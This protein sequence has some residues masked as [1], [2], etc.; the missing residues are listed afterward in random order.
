MAKQIFTLGYQ[1]LTLDVFIAC[2]KSEGLTTVIDVRANPLSRKRG[3]SKKALA[4]E[5]SAV[6]IE[7]KHLPVFGCPKSVRDRYKQDSDWVAYTRSYL[8]HLKG[9]GEALAQLA[10]IANAS[11]SCLICFETDYERCHRTFVARGVA[12]VEGLSVVHL[13][14]RTVIP[15][16]PVR[17]AA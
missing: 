2:L 7:Y 9:E 14:E 13:T 16:V 10:R 6:G 3:F 8:A 17:S 4:S 15:D 11:P 5:L 12:K 1:G